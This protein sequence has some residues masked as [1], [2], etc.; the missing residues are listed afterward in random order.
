MI[1]YVVVLV[2]YGFCYLFAVAVALFSLYVP[3]VCLF[4]DLIER[5]RLI[6]EQRK[7]WDRED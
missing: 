2:V 5:R 1:G 7:K 4:G 3:Y 6:A